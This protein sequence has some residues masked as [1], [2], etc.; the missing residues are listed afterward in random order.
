MSEY[1]LMCSQCFNLKPKNKLRLI[2]AAG[3][4]SMT[5]ETIPNFYICNECSEK[6]GVKK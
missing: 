5:G 3:T 4:M 2:D 6:R 1:L